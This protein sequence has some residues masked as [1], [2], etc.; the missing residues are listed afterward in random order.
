[1]N[2]ALVA[3]ISW[4]AGAL[5]S[6]TTNQLERAPIQQVTIDDSESS[7]AVI[8]GR[9]LNVEPMLVQAGG[10]AQATVRISTID[11]RGLPPIRAVTIRVAA[12]RQPVWTATMQPYHRSR[13]ETTQLVMGA[14][15]PALV[16]GSLV[17]VRVDIST[18]SRSSSVTV[19]VT[20]RAR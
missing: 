13:F 17:S 3:V 15:G 16:A 10:A 12:P 20:V 8:E 1:M 4:A 19:P 11:D 18:Q 9:V 5:F 14:D 6:T 7:R 2:T